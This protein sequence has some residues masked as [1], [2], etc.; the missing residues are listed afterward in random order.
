MWGIYDHTRT[1]QNPSLRT[2]LPFSVVQLKTKEDRD[3]VMQYLRN[4]P[5]VGVHGEYIQGSRNVP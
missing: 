4:T 1:M 3:D 2:L 5:I